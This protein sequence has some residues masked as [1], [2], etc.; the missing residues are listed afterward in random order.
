MTEAQHNL[1]DLCID[2]INGQHDAKTAEFYSLDA[3][4]G[5][6]NW[7]E[8]TWH[9]YNSRTTD[10]NRLSPPCFSR[11]KNAE[12]KKLYLFPI[13]GYWDWV[14]WCANNPRKRERRP[15]KK[16]KSHR[17][18]RKT[19]SDFSAKATLLAASK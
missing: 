17:T 8:S 2:R 5:A 7:T 1:S 4:L 3:V 12:G 16:I 14:I 6:H 10:T 15:G 9:A 18:M 13:E 19:T 11:G